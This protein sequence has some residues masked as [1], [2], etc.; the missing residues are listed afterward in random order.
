M[1]PAEPHLEGDRAAHRRDGRF[2]DAGGEVDLAHQRRAGITAGHALGRAPHVD[3]DDGGAGALR[4]ARRLAH[5]KRIA[6]GQLDHMRGDP[7]PLGP[8]A[9]LL[10][11][12]DEF[13]GRDHLRDDERRAV[14]AG[15]PPENHVRDAGQGSQ[16]GPAI[17]G[18]RPDCP[19][20]SA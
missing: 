18:D 19:I 20:A 2:D 13:V 16:N 5:P 11:A 3:V 17:E 6:A 1:I 4:E 10:G 14:T 7:L 8:Q 12:A 9:R 15:D